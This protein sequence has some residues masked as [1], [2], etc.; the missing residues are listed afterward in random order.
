MVQCVE[1]YMFIKW[2]YEHDKITGY[3]P[4]LRWVM[5]SLK[6]NVSS[7]GRTDE[8]RLSLSFETSTWQKMRNKQRMHSTPKFNSC[9]TTVYVLQIENAH[10]RLCA[11]VTSL[12][13]G[14]GWLQ[15]V[16]EPTPLFDSRRLE[17]TC[18]FSQ[19]KTCQVRR[20]F[21]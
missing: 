15:K 16:L 1:I 7:G 18:R 21:C 20:Q 12:A 14:I 10:T 5:E 4:K 9:I 11:G 13:H 17:A 19:Q 2:N 8:P 6:R 3:E